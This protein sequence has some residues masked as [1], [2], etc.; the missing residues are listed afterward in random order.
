MAAGSMRRRPRA[1]KGS[2]RTK[3]RNEE[4]TMPPDE[5]NKPRIEPPS[6]LSSKK[7]HAEMTEEE[8]Q[9]VDDWFLK[10]L[11]RTRPPMAPD[12]QGMLIEEE[13]NEAGTVPP[14]PEKQK[15]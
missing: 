2:G 6:V 12:P 10:S 13:N 5:K 15:K 8:R 14:P 7:T 1:R 3:T 11:F 9:A 4:A